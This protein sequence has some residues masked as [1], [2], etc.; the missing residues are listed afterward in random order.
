MINYIINIDSKN[1]HHMTLEK[2][3]IKEILIK[4]EQI[5][6]NMVLLTISINLK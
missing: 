5:L 2:P 3:K 1:F 4:I 6:I